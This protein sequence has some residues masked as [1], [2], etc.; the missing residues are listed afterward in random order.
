MN[1]LKIYGNLLLLVLCL[2]G[3]S[4]CGE[5][6]LSPRLE[7][8]LALAPTAGLE[9]NETIIIL[10]DFNVSEASQVKVQGIWAEG[11]RIT[12]FTQ[13]S[14]GSQLELRFTL[15]EAETVQELEVAASSVE[16]GLNV[17][18]IFLE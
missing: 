12:A 11:T 1:F 5:F 18:R 14:Q 2:G 3:L 16:Y 15:P 10:K 17:K 4:A 8:S 13:V 9:R 6:E 7:F